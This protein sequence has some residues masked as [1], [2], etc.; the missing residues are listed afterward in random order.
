MKRLLDK[1]KND[2]CADAAIIA[3]ALALMLLLAGLF[4][5][6]DG[7]H[8]RFTISG[9]TRI[10]VE[11]GQSFHDP[12]ARADAVGAFT[13][14]RPLSIES[15]GQVDTQRLG[16]YT[17]T[18]STRYKSKSYFAERIV[19][20]VDKTAPVI[21]LTTDPDYR[22]NWLEGY[23]EEGYSA[24]DAHDGD[25]T[26]AVEVSYRGES[27]VYTV[28]DAAGNR[29]EA[30]RH[31]SY[32]IGRPELHLAGEANATICP[33]PNYADPGYTAYDAYGNDLSPYVTVTGA[34]R[35][36]VPGEYTI[37][38]SISNAAGDTVRAERRVTVAAQAL[39]E[40]ITP[41]GKTIYLTFDDG[42]GPYTE[43]LLDVLQKYGVKAT[44]FVTGNREAY[45]GAI[46][47][48]YNEGHS[49][50]VHS[51][52]HDYGRIYSG[53][54]AFFED[55]CATEEMLHELTGSYTQLCRFPGGSSNTVSRFNHGIISR[56]AARLTEMNYSY[57]DWNVSSG[58]AGETR[59]TD[60]I[61][62]N[63]ISGCAGQDCSIVLQH[64]IKAYSV[65]AVERVIQWGLENGYTFLPL[66]LTSP[67]MHHNIAN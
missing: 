6:L 24:Y 64:D 22:A 32:A 42:P 60:K 51:Y 54:E 63:I 66:D 17:L 10:E 49:L 35:A 28:T 9:G 11:Y 57:F 25:L 38:Y 19:T 16:S 40:V 45:R 47:R 23:I 4:F 55:F 20:V 33:R 61:V 48:A 15:A 59:S 27:I 14:G 7:R 65:D 62:E 56:L 30:E 58:D 31:P 53:E 29:A 2:R 44:F 52:T 37:E 50:G 41:P 13:A 26:A 12:G 34:P 5:I 3:G 8:V 43:A 67:G 21:S 1:I 18:Y 39:P 36:D 46:T